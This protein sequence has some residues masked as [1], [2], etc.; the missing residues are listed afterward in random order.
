[1]LFIFLNYARLAESLDYV[2]ERLLLLNLK[3]INSSI[4]HANYDEVVAEIRFVEANFGLVQFGSCLLYLFLRLRMR[5]ED[6]LMRLLVFLLFVLN[7][8]SLVFMSLFG[9]CHF[10]L[11]LDHLGEALVECLAICQLVSYEVV[12]GLE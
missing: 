12:D 1:M 8:L 5:E 10:L 11:N 6:C 2:L 4:G 7:T 9:Q 3:L